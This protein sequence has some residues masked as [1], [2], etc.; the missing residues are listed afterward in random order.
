MLWWQAPGS[1][2][3]GKKLVGRLTAAPDAVG[4]VV[5]PL[6]GQFADWPSGRYLLEVDFAGS[7][8]SSWL[9]VLIESTPRG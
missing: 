1:S 4:A 6:G 8:T 5:D 2:G 9:G 7:T 3:E